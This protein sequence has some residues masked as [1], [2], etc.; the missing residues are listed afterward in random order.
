MMLSD[1]SAFSSL[2]EF[3]LTSFESLLKEREKKKNLKQT[4]SGGPG[5]GA[6]A[7]V[8][9]SCALHELWLWGDF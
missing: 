7:G 5:R 4:W 1:I 9:P 8:T 6:G 2:K 3:K